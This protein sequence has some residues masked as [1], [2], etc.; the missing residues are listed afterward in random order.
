M[1][2]QTYYDVR[3]RYTAARSVAFGVLVSFPAKLSQGR[4]WSKTPAYGR[5]IRPFAPGPAAR[6]RPARRSR[7]G[8]G[9]ARAAP[10]WKSRAA[11]PLRCRLRGEI[12]APAAVPPEPA[13][14]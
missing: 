4:H 10:R 6:V 2:R 7:T 3:L 1:I 12:A 9:P 8:G 11:N 14:G 5:R 13:P